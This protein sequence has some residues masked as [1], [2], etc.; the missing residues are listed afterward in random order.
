MAD[1]TKP[2][3]DEIATAEKDIFQDY[4]GTTLLNPDKV[5]KSESGGKGVELYED[6]LRDDKVGSTLQTR[7]L[8]VVGKEWEVIPASDKR[9]DQKVADYVKQVLSGFRYDDARKALLSG[10]VLGYKP[11][12]IMWEYSEGQVWIKD[13][14]G[15]AS[16]RFVF[17]TDRRMRMIT[18]GNMIEGEEIPDRKFVVY[19]NVSD[20]GSPYGDGLGRLL[21][22]PVWFKK[23]A[24]KFWMIFADKFGSPTAVGK[25]PAGSTTPAQKASL[26]DACEAI[27]QES[28]IT[29]PDGMLIELLEAK[30]TGSVNTY[31]TLCAFMNSAIAQIMLGQTLTSEVGSKGSY[32]A[33]KTHEDVREDYIKADADSLSE[34]LNGQLVKWIVDYNFPGYARTGPGYAGTGSGINRYPKVWIRTEPEDDLKALAERDKI[35][36]VDMGVPVATSYIYDTY[37]IPAPKE[38]EELLK[39]VPVQTEPGPVPAEPGKRDIGQAFAEKEIDWVAAYMERLVP[40]LISVRESGLKDIEAWLISLSVPPTHTEFV[41]QAQEILGAAFDKIDARAITETVSDMYV[42]Y[43]N[44]PGIETGFGG[45]DVRAINFLAG[46]DRFYVS[47]YIRNPEAQKIVADF[48]AQRYLEQGAPLFKRSNPED[49]RAFRDLLGQKLADLENWQVRRIVDTSVQ[50]TRNWASVAQLHEAGVTEIEIYEPTRDCG[51]CRSMDGQVI[52]VSTAY[53]RM[54]EQTS[55]SPGEYE[56]DLKSVLPVEANMGAIVDQGRLPPYH[57]HCHGRVISRVVK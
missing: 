31:E 49:L 16:R 1:S 23:N 15:K 46:V 11:A 54:Q 42:K 40:A 53:T 48:I 34:C 36:I 55:M 41:T 17:G 25:Y 24:I 6:L 14:I 56:R 20:N 22:W 39:P 38:G 10:V 21:Y 12:E 30:R 33:S 4:I 2:V 37:G 51:F 27:Q 13:I 19:T 50:R 45:P 5:L 18:L 43:R 29:I 3:L 47:S 28:A 8:A 9:Q 57:P 35:I 26:L 44:A 7:K 32:A 52:S